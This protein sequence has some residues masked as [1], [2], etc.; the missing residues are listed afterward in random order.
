M[1]GTCEKAG[2]AAIFSPKWGS[3]LSAVVRLSAE[4]HDLGKLDPLNQHVLSN[5]AHMSLPVQHEDAGVAHLLD[6]GEV[7]CIRR[8][9]AIIVHAHHKGLPFLVEEDN[10]EGL[11]LHFA[12]AIGSEGQPTYERTND[13]LESYRTLHH[14]VTVGRLDP[15]RAE[16]DAS[17][18]TQLLLRIALSCLVDA[19]HFD[20]ARHYGNATLRPPT[21]ERWPE[22]SAA[23]DAYVKGLSLGKADPRGALRDRVYQTCKEV[24]P[25][26]ALWECDSPVGTGKTTAVMSHL[27]RQAEAKKLRR[28]FV[29][30]PFTNII[31]QAVDV[32]RKSLVLPGEDPEAVVAAAH[33]KA[34]YENPDSRHFAAL[35]DARVVVTT[36]VQFFE[37]LAACSTGGLRKLHALVGAGVFID[38]SH[39]A[40]PAKLWPQAWVWIKQLAAE[41]GCHFVL[42]SGSLNRIWTVREIE[43]EPMVLPP[44]VK[45]SVG[46]DSL[47]EEQRRWQPCS[48]E[49]PLTL[50]GL[51]DWLDEFDGPRLV[52]VNTVQIAAALA[53]L[54]SE[55]AGAKG[56][57]Q[58]AVLHLSTALT[59]YH[60]ALTLRHI[61]ARLAYDTETNWTLVATSCVEAGVDFSFR[62]GFRQRAS[63]ASLLQSSGRV[64]RSNEFG[65]AEVWD[66]QLV[67]G[68][69]VNI[70]P[71]FEDSAEILGD[72]FKKG[73]VSPEHC[74]AA[75]SAEI[76]Q[77][78]KA[79]LNEALRKAEEALNFPEIERLF[80]VIDTKTKTVVISRAVRKRIERGEPVD[81]RELQRHSVQIYANKVDS[82]RVDEAA[83]LPGV[84]LWHLPYDDFIGYMAGVLPLVEFWEQ[85]GII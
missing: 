64:N 1:A 19:D 11:C 17:G 76:L 4:S 42:G 57:G 51:A 18:Y 70:N 69:L 82:L 56:R 47:K 13:L 12:D 61:K 23:L 59:P 78:R 71:A 40:L 85:G 44:L 39:A 30:L 66:F 26:P 15:P 7:S 22:R 83:S 48:R 73:L 77:T 27:L 84:F 16:P 65:G 53:N 74:T 35:W 8:L 37:T 54:L 79:D 68:G 46:V 75:L 25:S 28:I 63:L 45:P 80:K 31:D 2:Q 20:T 81:W 14:R 38:E 67:Q 9:A 32:Y 34:E 5:N 43:P 62:T 72:F 21:Q 33:H 49:Q 36:A 55:R 50:D 41:W 24:D 3:A 6:E 10:R 60:R 52:I 29:V 58:G